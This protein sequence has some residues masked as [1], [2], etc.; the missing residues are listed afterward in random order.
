MFAEGRIEFR[1]TGMPVLKR[2]LDEQPGVPLQ[3]FWEDVRLSTASPERLGFPTQKPEALLDRVIRASSREGDT[4]LDPFCGCGTAVSVAQR[5]GRHW[6]GIDITH[7]AIGL[8]RSRLRDAYG[9]S[10]AETYNVVGE[11][12]SFY[13]AATLADHDRYQFQYWALGL[14]GARPAPPD[15]KKGADRGIDGRLY[16]HDDAPSGRT[17]QVILSVKSGNVDVSQVRDLRGVIEREK[18]EL[19]GFLTL[20]DPSAP[21]RTEAVGAG[22][23]TSPWGTKHPRMQIL[24]VS[25]IL[26]GRR[27]DLPHIRDERTFKRAPKA[28]AEADDPPMLPF[29]KS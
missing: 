15:R 2:F 19:G 6:V 11:P 8:I 13:D 21:M 4:V 25:E 9:E 1:K 23:Y 22:F 17:K 16:F 18:A 26:N 28:R 14:V 5:L 7:L 24:T 3:D 10:I 20:N 27:L 29:G 12:V